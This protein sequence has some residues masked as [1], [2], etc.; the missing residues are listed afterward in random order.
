MHARAQTHAQPPPPPTPTHINTNTKH[1][2]IRRREG[3]EWT[4]LLGN[5][6]EDPQCNT[7]VRKQVPGQA[8]FEELQQWGER[9]LAVWVVGE[10][11]G[12]GKG[13]GEARS[14]GERLFAPRAP[15]ATEL[16]CLFW[17]MGGV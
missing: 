2:P 1:S 9:H 4:P 6:L 5:V 7:D 8:V 12:D 15:C 14:Q 16:H 17:F 3:R 13:G 10:G 11:W